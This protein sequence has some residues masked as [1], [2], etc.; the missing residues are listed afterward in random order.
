MLDLQCEGQACEGCQEVIA[1]RYFLHVNGACWHTDC[2]RCCVC[3]SSLEQEES[4]FV[5]DENIYCRRDYIR[6]VETPATVLSVSFLNNS[7]KEQLVLN[8]IPNLFYIGF[9]FFT[10]R[11]SQWSVRITYYIMLGFFSIWSEFGTKCS[12]CYRK[13]QATDWVRRA[14]ENVYH[15]ACFAC[16]SCQRQLSTGEEFALSGDQLLCLRHYTSLV[17][18]DTD[19]GSSIFNFILINFY[20]LFFLSGRH[21]CVCVFY[22][23]FVSSWHLKSF[24]TC[25]F[26]F[27]DA[28]QVYL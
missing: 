5:K 13:I 19:K 18:G 7:P 2:L 9:A 22:F 17:E 26:S 16:D 23:K 8:Y 6:Y 15:L 10:S 27:F 12:K 11:L 4:C 21:M 14:R 24:M 20:F 25:I 1:D 28:I 3:C